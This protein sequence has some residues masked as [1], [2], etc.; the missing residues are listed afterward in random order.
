MHSVML[1]PLDGIETRLSPYVGD[2]FQPLAL[3]VPW[4]NGSVPQPPSG[5]A[6]PKH[7][8]PSIVGDKRI[9]LTKKHLTFFH[10]AHFFLPLGMPAASGG[11]LL[12]SDGPWAPTLALDVELP[13]GCEIVNGSDSRL[14]PLAGGRSGR[15]RVRVVSATKGAGLS[16]MLSIGV[17][18]SDRSLEGTNHTVGFRAL[19]SVSGT[20]EAIAADAGWL[21][22]SV[23]MVARPAFKLPSAMSTGLSFGAGLADWPKST[24]GT[25]TPL[26]TYRALALNTVPASISNTVDDGFSGLTTAERQGAEWHGLRYG[27]AGGAWGSMQG[28]LSTAP[29]EVAKA[30]MTAVCP[31][32]AQRQV[33]AERKKWMQAAEFYATVKNATGDDGFDMAYDGC[34]REQDINQT[35][36]QVAATQPDVVIYDVEG[37]THYELW[38][39]SIR[40]SSNAM[41][42]RQAGESLSALARRMTSDWLSTLIEPTRKVSP[43]TVSALWDGEA[44]D[45]KGCCSGK[46]LGIFDWKSLEAAGCWSFPGMCTPPRKSVFLPKSA[47]LPAHFSYR[48]LGFADN[49]IK[50]LDL[51]AAR[52]RR[53]KAL[54]K[55][56]W[57]LLPTFT[58]MGAMAFA[59][60]VQRSA[61]NFDVMVQALANGATGLSV[62]EDPYVD[63]P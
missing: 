9:A 38:Q 17:L 36:V 48:L 24:D 31:G 59:G 37:F 13:T 11:S 35:I 16:T 41:S 43:G 5:F 7:V 28:H 19:T 3:I 26:S 44:Q 25:V 51:L 32:L 30:N 56:G 40:L 15:H 2:D 14:A 12:P 49:G 1:S 62:F 27:P 46:E 29:A 33:A 45:N 55:P 53:E 18:F 21:E 6:G 4:S 58:P 54:L 23:S 47:G 63:D 34:L 52:L 22:V 50:N 61:Y 20:N 8:L 10:G 57:M 42:R 60:G 39:R